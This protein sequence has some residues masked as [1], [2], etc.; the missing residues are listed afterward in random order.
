ME[1]KEITDLP[2]PDMNYRLV[3]NEIAS[4]KVATRPNAK[5]LDHYAKADGYHFQAY[6]R[7]SDGVLLFTDFDQKM[8]TLI[9]FSNYP[10]L[11]RNG[12]IYV[13]QKDT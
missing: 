9:A 13:D 2:W 1:I 10:I 11:S 8:K 7:N 6:M 5:M 12:Q 4:I 3:S